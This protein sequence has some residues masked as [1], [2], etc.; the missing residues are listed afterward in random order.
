M[1]K[2]I[3]AMVHPF[4]V[5]QEVS[6]YD[7]GECIK[8]MNCTLDNIENTI[9]TLANQYNIKQ[10]DLAGSQIYNL[11]IRDNINTNTNFNKN[12]LNITIH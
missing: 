8:T 7:N 2:H 9:L 3:I 1:N 10:I 11:K 5:E 6:V 4:V 12:E